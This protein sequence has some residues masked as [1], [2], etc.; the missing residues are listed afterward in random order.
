MNFAAEVGR[1][2]VILV[3]ISKFSFLLVQRKFHGERFLILVEIFLLL[4]FQFAWSWIIH[5]SLIAKALTFMCDWRYED[6]MDGHGPWSSIYLV[7]KVKDTL[8]SHFDRK[9]EMLH[10]HIGICENF[11]YKFFKRF[12]LL[13]VFRTSIL[14]VDYNDFV[15][16][17][18]FYGDG[19][20]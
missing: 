18:L 7:L 15:I 9:L 12:F 5:Q 1:E 4:I 19:G 14:T 16:F 8:R 20:F 6:R 3:Y 10:F 11:I 17:L 2:S 13:N